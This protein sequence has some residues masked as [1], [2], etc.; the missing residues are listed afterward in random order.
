MRLREY[1]R[2]PTRKQARDKVGRTAIVLSSL[3]SCR[4]T[5]L[6]SHHVP[7]AFFENAMGPLERHNSKD[8]APLGCTSVSK[9]IRTAKI[10]FRV[11]VWERSNHLFSPCAG[12]YL[13]LA[14]PPQSRSVPFE[15]STSQWLY[16]RGEDSGALLAQLSEL[17]RCTEIHQPQA[18]PARTLVPR[19]LYMAKFW[20]LRYAQQNAETMV[21]ADGLAYF[22]D[23]RL[24]SWGIR[25]ATI[26]VFRTLIGY[27]RCIL[28]HSKD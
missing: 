18:Q 11:I 28:L 27:T 6:V 26:C 15:A 13:M 9:Q 12:P 1:R 17:V 14:A 19:I 2:D 4:A 20:D 3:V 7:H 25:T 16:A 8:F 10:D 22:A 24:L 21:L 23:Q 5:P